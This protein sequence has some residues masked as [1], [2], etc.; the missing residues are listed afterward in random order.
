MP[1]VTDQQ[2]VELTPHGPVA[3][4]VITAPAPTGLITSGP[5]SRGGTITGA[6]EPLTQ[7]EQDASS[8]AV[9]AGVNGDFFNPSNSSPNGI[10][11][12]GGQ[13]EHGPTPARSSIGFDANGTMHVGR[14][15]FAGTWQ[16]SGQRRPLSGINQQPRGKPDRALHPGLG[17]DDA[18]SPE[19]GE[20]LLEP[21][22][23]ATIDTDLT[24]TVSAVPS[25][26]T[27]IPADGAVLVATGTPGRQAPGGGAGGRH[28]DGPPDP[29]GLPGAP[30]SRRSAAARCS[31]SG[32]K[33]VFATGENF[34]SGQLVS[35]DARAAVGQLADGSMILVAVDGGHPGL[36]RRHDHL[37]ARADD[38]PPGRR[39]RRRA[40]V[41]EV[42]D[43]RLRR[44]PP[45][46]AERP[47]RRAAREGGAARAVLRASM[48]PR[49]RRRC[50]TPKT[51]PPASSSP[52]GSCARRP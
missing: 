4:T 25:G 33:P 30:S 48:H 32:G 23:A 11:M 13:L 12:V 49:R 52:T 16:G 1:G 18:R 35:H 38:G 19:R 29:P 9:V 37:R 21:F 50:S 8:S 5:C 2:Q 40:R 44:A 22:P 7:L 36:Q 42:R 39:H 51:P 28:R 3:Y 24:A 6:R 45:E 20:V 43:R 41:R 27:P 34:L 17:S 26:A 46:P 10:V 14:I 31:S 47:R 15:S